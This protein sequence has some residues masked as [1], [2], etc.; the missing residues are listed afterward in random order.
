[1]GLGDFQASS[2]LNFLL[3][4]VNAVVRRQAGRER[5]DDKVAGAC[6]YATSFVFCTVLGA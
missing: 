4:K 3:T 5:K 6:A 1:M 2:P